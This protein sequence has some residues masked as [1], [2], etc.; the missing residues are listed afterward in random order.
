MLC[1]EIG[2]FKRFSSG[3][4]LAAYIGLTPREFSSGEH[5]YK[6]RITGQGNSIVR[7]YLIESS[8]FLIGKDPVKKEYY[9][10]IK[11]NSGSAKKAI[12]AFARKLINRIH[13]IVINNQCYTI[14][15]I[16]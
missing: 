1:F 5:V 4:K 12:V 14:G 13:S 9:N 3:K 7:S 16:E 6:G 11:I 15:L 10:R 8:W 2:N